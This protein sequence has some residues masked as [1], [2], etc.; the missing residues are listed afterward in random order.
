LDK[1]PY[2][3]RPELY[4]LIENYDKFIKNLVL[5]RKKELKSG[6][7]LENR[8]LLSKMLLTKHEDGSPYMSIN[9]INVKL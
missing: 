8:D 5:E 2:F 4:E 6:S 9:E 3:T 7:V 1:L